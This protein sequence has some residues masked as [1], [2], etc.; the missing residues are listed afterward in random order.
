MAFN[1]FQKF[2][3][4]KGLPKASVGKTD[5]NIRREKPVEHKIV[6]EKEIQEKKIIKQRPSEKNIFA[7]KY[8]VSPHIS[9]KASLLQEPSGKNEKISYI[10]RVK[11]IAT[12]QLLKKAIEDRYDVKI[13][14]INIINTHS[15]EIRRGKIIGKKA[16]YKKAIV[17]LLPNNKIEQL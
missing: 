7:S 13:S 10:F 17:T 3:Q 6:A 4:K 2:S 16:G 8:I 14:S 15:K 11:N 1:F 12:K 9:E 5:K